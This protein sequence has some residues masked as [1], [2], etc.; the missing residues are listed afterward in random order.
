MVRD[1]HLLRRSILH[2][3]QQ[4]ELMSTED[5]K[6]SFQD[7]SLNEVIAGINFLKN[8]RM[9][10]EVDELVELSN[11]TKSTPIATLYN[12]LKVGRTYDR[13]QISD[14]IR[15]NSLP[16]S[17]HNAVK[18]LVKHS[19]LTKKSGNSFRCLELPPLLGVSQE[20]EI[21]TP[22]VKT[23][24]VKTPIVK[25]PIVSVSATR[26]VVWEVLKGG[27]TRLELY[28][29]LKV[30]HPSLTKSVI[31]NSVSRLLK[32]GSIDCHQHQYHQLEYVPFE[33]DIFYN[34]I[35][36]SGYLFVDHPIALTMTKKL[37]LKSRSGNIIN[38]LIGFRA[39][40]CTDVKGRFKVEELPQVESLGSDDP[41]TQNTPPQVDEMPTQTKPKSVGACIFDVEK[42]RQALE[43]INA[44][45]ELK[46]REVTECR[47]KRDE[48]RE[49]SRKA[50]EEAQRLEDK[51]ISIEAG[52]L[53][54]I[55]K[56]RVDFKDSQDQLQTAL[57]EGDYIRG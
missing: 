17:G 53:E 6:N 33:I 39:L 13:K 54:S 8:A 23:P 19:G 5:I 57:V 18:T 52:Y 56:A 12:S 9:V 43:Q 30:S 15:T 42:S 24:A 35:K 14:L 31:F 28:E 36:E 29:A 47:R 25:T 40:S 16:I 22:S 32:N 51:A 3:L 2:K 49:E 45:S 4:E 27:K 46:I 55:E 34:E 50:L 20:G 7:V 1:T 44:E 11:S 26:R 21:A 37:N 48:A 41:P 38:S 10:N